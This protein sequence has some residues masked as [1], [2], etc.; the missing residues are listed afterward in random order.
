[1][2]IVTIAENSHEGSWLRH[3]YTKFHIDISSPL[4]VIGVWNVE[5]RTHTHTR[6]HTSRCQLKIKFL[7]VLDY[8]EYFDT[9]NSE[10]IF[11]ENSFLGEE[12]KSFN[13]T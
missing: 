10:I 3:W 7:Y 8:S 12:A 6:T 5:N 9:N 13:F 11:H 4:W 1:M 2:K